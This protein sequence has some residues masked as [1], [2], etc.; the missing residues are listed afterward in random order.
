MLYISGKSIREICRILE[1]AE[2]TFYLWLGSDLF[3]RCL[4][5]WQIKIR[6]DAD[7]K[8]KNVVNKALEKLDLILDNP[9]DFSDQHYLKA[10]ELSLNLRGKNN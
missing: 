2:S 5:R 6:I 9:D 1:I 10:I 4:T 7:N 8:I 3:V